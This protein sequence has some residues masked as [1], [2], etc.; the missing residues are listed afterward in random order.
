M[1]QAG[2]VMTARNE[3]FSGKFREEIEKKD[4]TKIPRLGYPDMGSGRYSALLT[5]EQWVKFN[6]YQRA[7]Y[8]SMEMVTTALVL[9][10]AAGWHFPLIGAALGI[11]YIVAR[12]IYCSGYRR[13][14][15]IG[16]LSGSRLQFP[17]LV[18]LLLT[19]LYGGF[20]A[21]GGVG[22]FLKILQGA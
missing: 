3:V 20:T 5:D 1:L 18:G 6:N 12:Q 16:R 22:G 2:P 13:G 15:A 7:H 8:N 17:T 10:L 21:G 11:V 9:E 19:A 14:G 4:G